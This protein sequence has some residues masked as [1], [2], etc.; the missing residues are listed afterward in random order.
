MQLNWVVIL[1][2]GIIPLIVG[3]LWYNDKTFGT[4]WMNESGMTKEKMEGSN[5]GLIFGLT[6][7]FGVM[8]AIATMQLVI[9]QTHYYSI[10]ANEASLK[11]ASSPL[12]I[13]TKTFMDAYGQNFRTFKHGVLHGVLSA[14]F[15]VLPVFGINALFERRSPK[16]VLIHV[17]Y[18][19]VTLGLMGGIICGFA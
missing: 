3:F 19:V 11:D 9:H 2:A 12:S 8:L 1:G 5:M 17:G 16:Y 18:W 13:S 10:L 7:L 6:L 15:I 4:V 14:L